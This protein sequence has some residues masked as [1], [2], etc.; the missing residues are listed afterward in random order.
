MA[1]KLLQAVPGTLRVTLCA[2]GGDPCFQVQ[3]V[4]DHQERYSELFMSF[5]LI[6]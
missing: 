1:L 6:R 4:A 3:G 2:E 5:Q